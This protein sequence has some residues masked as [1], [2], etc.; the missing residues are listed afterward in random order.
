[1]I[2]T[3]HGPQVT[4]CATWPRIELAARDYTVSSF[5]NSKPAT[6]LV[7]FQR[8]GSNAIATSDCG[9]GED[10]GT[11]DALPARSRLPDRLR[12]DRLSPRVDP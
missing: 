12:S 11:Q 6:A 2:K 4:A 10:G 7:I 3:G 8:P 5:L 9:A 1:V